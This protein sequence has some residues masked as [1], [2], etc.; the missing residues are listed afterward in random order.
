VAESGKFMPVMAIVAPPLA[1]ADEGET[2]EA[3]IP[4][5]IG[6]EVEAILTVK[7]T[8]PISFDRAGV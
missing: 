3:S 6:V 1:G 5:W 2:E 4:I 8:S 7:G